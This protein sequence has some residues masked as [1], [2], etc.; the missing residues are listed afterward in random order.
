MNERI[1]PPVGA[2]IELER[3][4][5]LEKK[6]GV[7]LFVEQYA[8]PEIKDRYYEVLKPNILLANNLLFLGNTLDEVERVLKMREDYSK[9]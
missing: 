7:E 4:E 5:N 8:L 9:L 6:Y 3:M 1:I 2:T